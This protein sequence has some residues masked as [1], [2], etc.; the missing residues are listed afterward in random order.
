M[1]NS[2]DLMKRL[3]R[4]EKNVEVLTADVGDLKRAAWKTAEILA[5]HGERLSSMDGRLSSMDGRLSS[6]DER[7]GLVVDRLD[8]LIS[9]TIQ[10]RTSSAE[11]LGDI[12]RRLTRLE[13]RVG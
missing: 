13:E 7:L 1:A 12:E 2:A 3:A 11:R 8:R 6:M 9:V 4:L 5:D 10:E